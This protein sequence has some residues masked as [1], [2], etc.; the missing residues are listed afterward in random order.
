MAHQ[1]TL[2]NPMENEEI[3]Q[4]RI[5]KRI[6]YN[7]KPITEMPLKSAVSKKNETSFEKNIF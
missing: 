2:S 1:K 6:K 5:R 4:K 7:R 3:F